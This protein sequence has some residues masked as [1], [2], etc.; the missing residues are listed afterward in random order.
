MGYRN[1]AESL[2]EF[3]AGQAFGFDNV[4][5]DNDFDN[6]VGTLSI[7][8][9]FYC[10]CGNGTQGRSRYFD[11]PKVVNA[12]TGN[13]PRIAGTFDPPD[14]TV[15]KYAKR[16][17]LSP[18]NVASINNYRILRYADVLLLQAEA[19]LQSGGS[20]SEAIGYINHVRARARAMGAKP[21]PA[22]FLTSEYGTAR[23]SAQLIYLSFETQYSLT[24]INANQREKNIYTY[25]SG[26]HLLQ[27]V[28]FFTITAC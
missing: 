22:D 5:L 15:L 27:G 28:R 6:A 26:L 13:D 23:L 8:W 20:T 11:T 25:N 18:S 21:N 10:N 2:F 9:G 3:Q 7:Y 16:D 1:N 4:W 12:F 14:R 17:K 19:V 24:V